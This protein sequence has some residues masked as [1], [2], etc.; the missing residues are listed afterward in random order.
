MKVTRVDQNECAAEGSGV[1]GIANA[2]RVG[3]LLRWKGRWLDG[4]MR[5]TYGVT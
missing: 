3:I 1:I 2:G 5:R 4:L